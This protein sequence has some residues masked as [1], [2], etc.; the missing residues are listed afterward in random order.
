MNRFPSIGEHDGVYN[1]DPDNYRRGLLEPN[2]D[3]NKYHRSE[4]NLPPLDWYEFKDAVAATYACL[5]KNA[6]LPGFDEQDAHNFYEFA[7][8]DSIADRTVQAWLPDVRVLAP[9]LVQAIQQEVLLS[10]PL[11]RVLVGSDEP[12]RAVIIYPDIVRVGLSSENSDW[13]TDLAK[14]VEREWKSRT[15]REGPERRQLNYLREL[16]PSALPN[17]TAKP[18]ELL[19]VFDNYRGNIAN[20]KAWVLFAGRN[21]EDITIEPTNGVAVSDTYPVRDDG[22][23]GPLFKEDDAS[24]W[25][26]AFVYP[27]E[28]RQMRFKRQKDYKPLPG[29]V[30]EVSIQPEEVIY[31]SDLKAKEKEVRFSP[32]N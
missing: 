3:F 2:E 30:F 23:F 31:E 24:V 16:I 13:R 27:L 11:W 32:L 25:L 14:L 12:A 28:S 4:Q 8:S 22:Y 29:E 7:L 21:S 17:L 26:R 19:G 6:R 20:W 1:V 18:F 9:G 15:E 5:W 10:R